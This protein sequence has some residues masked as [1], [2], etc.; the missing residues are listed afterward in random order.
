MRYWNSL[1]FNLYEIKVI[2]L[3]TDIRY[4]AWLFNNGYIWARVSLRF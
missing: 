4:V 1:T 3:R 2:K